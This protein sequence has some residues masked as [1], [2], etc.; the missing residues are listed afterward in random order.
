MVAT[1]NMGKAGDIDKWTHN[2]SA[3]FQSQMNYGRRVEVIGMQETSAAKAQKA[4]TQ[5][6]KTKW[7]L[8]NRGDAALGNVSL[9][10]RASRWT[11]DDKEF[12]DAEYRESWRNVFR[13]EAE[14]MIV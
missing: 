14:I 8:M 7:S 1:V 5:L 11:H 6:G 2:Q 3:A 10:Y 9:L 13:N 12:D 4:H